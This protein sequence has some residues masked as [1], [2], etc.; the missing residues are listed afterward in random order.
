MTHIFTEAFLSISASLAPMPL[1]LAQ[2][3]GGKT[4]VGWLIVL[5]C[6]ALGLLVVCRPS[7]RAKAETKKR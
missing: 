5:L 6:I 1:I 3:G 7:G 2:T 4:A